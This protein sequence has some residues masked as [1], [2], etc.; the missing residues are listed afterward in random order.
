MRL[1][2]FMSRVWVHAFV[3]MLDLGAAAEDVRPVSAHGTLGMQT[4]PLCIKPKY[5]PQVH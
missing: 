4:P 5:S 1:R 2:P 3:S